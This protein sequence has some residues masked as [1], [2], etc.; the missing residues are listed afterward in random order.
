MK[1]SALQSRAGSLSTN[2]DQGALGEL[3]HP[4]LQVSDC[5]VEVLPG[6]LG[7]V[8]ESIPEKSNED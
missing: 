2:P 1:A 7:G 5:K 4:E 3:P 8:D 6:L